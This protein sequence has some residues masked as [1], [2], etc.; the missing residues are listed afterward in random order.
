MKT[1][2]SN[3]QVAHL[4]A[5][6]S[7]SHA[8][9]NSMSFK[10]PNLYSYST[11]IAAIHETAK[12]GIRVYLINSRKYSPTTSSRHM[13]Q[14]SNAIRGLDS[15]VVIGVPEVFNNTVYDS[16]M[17][18][19]SLS[20][21]THSINQSYLSAQYK[22][23]AAR[24]M[25]VRSL[26]YWHEESLRDKCTAAYAYAR[27]FD[28]PSPQELDYARDWSSAQERQN[29]LARDPKRVAREAAKER[30]RAERLAW[31]AKTREERLAEDLSKFRAGKPVSSISGFWDGDGAAYLRVIDNGEIVQTSRGASV[32]VY[33]AIRA[34]GFIRAVM[35]RGKEWKRNGE[36]CPVGKFQIDTI[37]VNGDIKAGCH[38]IKW[39]EIEA[40]ALA[41]GV[42]PWSDLQG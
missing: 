7:Q 39:P 32:P 5:N 8:R 20:A 2:V 27:V 3:S 15:V 38:F 26:G 17:P 16:G 4:W 30:A 19:P 14:V 35:A 12:T 13:P 21:R 41:L 11:C 28:L 31:D 29:R 40:I 24:L 10:G 6:Q 18:L 34:I 1:V 22:D 25:R 42:E 9:S 37:A 33:S 23:Y 36:Q